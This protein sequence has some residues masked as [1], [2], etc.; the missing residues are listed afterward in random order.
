MRIKTLRIAVDEIRIRKAAVP[1]A[2]VTNLTS[3]DEVLLRR[4]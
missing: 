4:P 3:V 1:V 2:L